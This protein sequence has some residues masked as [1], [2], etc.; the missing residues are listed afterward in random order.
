[1]SKKVIFLDRDGVINQE[2]N[3]LHKIED[4]KFINGIFDSL[5]TIQ[6][7]GYHFIVITN[8]SGIG[9]GL[10]S[11]EDYLL[12]DKWM[13][14]EFE[15]NGV[16]ILFSIHCP[17]IPEQKCDCRKPKPGMF[18]NCF[19]L[20]KI[21]KDDS[22]M[23]GDSERDIEAAIMAGINNTILVRSG[24]P[25]SESTTKASIVVD[26]IKDIKKIITF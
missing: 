11:E 20:F 26:S 14:K 22:W 16:K 1:M 7:L 13:K 17:H 4:F 24:H 18:I 15:K 6:D 19:K 12:L 10:Y 2:K 25:I 8:Q 3:Y 23:V 5:R 21:S 9:R